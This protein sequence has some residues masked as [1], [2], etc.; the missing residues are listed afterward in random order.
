MNA[1]PYVSFDLSAALK[2]KV[3]KIGAYVA[4]AKK[5]QDPDEPQDEWVGEY[6]RFSDTDALIE[7]TLE[8]VGEDSKFFG[9]GICQRLVVKLIGDKVKECPSAGDLIT[10]GYTFQYRGEERDSGWQAPL[11]KITQVRQDENTKQI[12][13]YG[14]DLIYDAAKY[15]IDDLILVPP[16]TVKDVANAIF[17]KIVPNFITAEDS[18][19]EIYGLNEEETCFDTIYTYGANFE[20]TENLREV[21]DEI[22]EVTQTVYYFSEWNQ[23]IFR[24]LGKL[25]GTPETLSKDDY[26]KLTTSENRRLG[27][28]ASVT[29]LGDNVATT[30]QSG[31]TQYVRDNDFWS[32]RTDIEYLLKDAIDAVGGL[33]IAPFTCEWRGYL[34]NI[35]RCLRLEKNDGTFVES[36]VLDDVI[37]YNGTLSEVTQWKY[38][39]PDDTGSNPSNLGEALKQTFAKVDKANKTI[40]IVASDVTD[41]QNRTSALEIN[42][43]SITA[44]VQN[45][46]KQNEDSYAALG[47]S[48]NEISKKVNAQITSEDVKIQIEQQ[49]EGGVESVRTATGFTFDKDGLTINKSGT[50]M[51]TQITEDG[52]SVYRGNT[53]VLTANNEG[54][55]ATNLHA[56]TY[57]IIG[58]NSRFEDYGYNRTGCFWIGP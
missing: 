42:T 51:K 20:G 25:S 55:Q 5:V 52:M 58:N 37:K 32:L 28:I 16:Y 43:D 19:I 17:H 53:E 33:T 8:R 14:Y 50:E 11:F 22:A 2:E 56:R 48:I 7:F 6:M 12:T 30:G 27:A 54:V 1:T 21:L 24:R 47:D 39:D 26:F 13:L 9:F 46:Q 3:R 44:S 35:G 49:L 4:W 34:P 18:P 45:I 41:L 36:Y 57:L 40:E 29:E 23:L 38:T 10:V 31:T 15:T